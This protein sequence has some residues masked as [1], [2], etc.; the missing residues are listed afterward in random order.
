MGTTN[1][2][3]AINNALWPSEWACVRSRPSA[4][5]PGLLGVVKYT[6]TY[7]HW[8]TPSSQTYVH[9]LSLDNSEFSN[10]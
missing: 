7:C 1:S 3:A 2:N 4:T 5:R 6:F 8:T 10:R 9:V